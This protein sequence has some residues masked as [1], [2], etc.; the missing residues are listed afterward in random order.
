MRQLRWAEEVVSQS[1]SGSHDGKGGGMGLQRITDHLEGWFAGARIRLLTMG[2]KP[3][4]YRPSRVLLWNG[5]RYLSGCFLRGFGANL[6][7]A[8]QTR[9]R[10]TGCVQAFER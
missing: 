7:F 9:K 3:Y 4:C 8:I 6:A 2:R 5:N 10:Y 1:H